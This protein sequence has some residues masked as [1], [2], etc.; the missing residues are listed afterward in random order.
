MREVLKEPNA[1][2]LSSLFQ[3][4]WQSPHSSFY[5]RKYERAGLNERDLESAALEDIPPLTRAELVETNPDDRLFIKPEEVA[6]TAHTSGTTSGTP[7]LLYFSMPEKGDFEPALG[8][9]ANRLLT[10]F[11]PYN[12]NLNFW[13]VYQCRNAKRRVTPVFAE[14]Q[15]LANSAVIAAKANVDGIY[16]T[17]TIALALAE[18]IQKYYDPRRIKLLVIA[19]ELCTQASR[20]HLQ[21]LYPAAAIAHIYGSTEIATPSALPC[22]HIVQKETNLLHINDDIF[23]AAELLDGELVLTYDKNKAMP[24]VRYR[25]GDLFEIVDEHCLCGAPTVRILGRKDMD[26]IRISGVEIQTNDVERAL[27]GLTEEIGH[28]YQ[29]HFYEKMGGGRRKAHVVIEIVPPPGRMLGDAFGELIIEHLLDAWR[30]SA[31]STLRDAISKELFEKPEIHFVPELSFK[32]EKVRRLV[33]H[34]L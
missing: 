6:F 23:I 4:I 22:A 9:L 20:E 31:T 33:S 25:T 15:N 28:Q 14:Y 21:R 3:S 30:L 8:Y 26:S 34:V 7:L 11:P 19:A 2:E 1:T 5:R 29:L 24:L 32:S 12:K 10:V 27:G 16:A 18:Y 17:P 13:F